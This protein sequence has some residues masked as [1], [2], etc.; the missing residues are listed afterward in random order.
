MTT[1]HETC[2]A[3]IAGHL[4]S[5]LAD[6]KVFHAAELRGDDEAPGLGALADYGLCFDYV[7]GD[8]YSDQPEGYFRWQLSWGGPSDEFRFYADAAQKCHRIEYWFLDWA[9]GA[10]KTLAGKRK[11]LLLFFFQWFVD[12]TAVESALRNAK[13]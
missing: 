1:P 10:K 9:D 7:A 4:N 3:R 12:V 11:D 8:T 6:L 13:T 5:R 2:K